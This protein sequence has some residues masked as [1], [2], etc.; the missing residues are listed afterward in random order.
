MSQKRVQIDGAKQTVKITTE[1]D[2][3]WITDLS[4]NGRSIYFS[5]NKCW[6]A[7]GVVN[8]IILKINR[9][10]VAIQSKDFIIE[11]KGKTAIYITMPENNTGRENK[12]VINLEAGNYFDDITII[13]KSK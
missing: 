12:L 1:G 4:Y 11:K 2:W 13:Q 9:E 10:I 6:D 8:D 7:N 3:W 5:D